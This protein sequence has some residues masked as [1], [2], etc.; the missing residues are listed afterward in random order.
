[1]TLAALIFSGTL[2]RYPRLRVVLSESG[3]GWLP[4]LLERMDQQALL[5]AEC[6]EFY[7]DA[8]PLSLAPSAYFRRQIW[9]TFQVDQRGIEMLHHIGE[10]RVMWA[11]DY[12]HVDGTWPDSRAEITRSLHSLK[13][14]QRRKLLHDNAFALYFN[15]NR[16]A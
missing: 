3:I 5:F 11:S 15:E 4:F 14:G 10:D 2:E 9:A 12:P 1:E 8:V 6:A 13:P 7:P 16:R